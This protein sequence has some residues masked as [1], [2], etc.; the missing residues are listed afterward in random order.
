MASGGGPPNRG[1]GRTREL[2]A[3]AFARDTARAGVGSVL[4]VAGPAGSGKTWVCEAV[5]E[6]AAG[7]GFRVGWGT[8]WPGDG[9]PPLW[10]WQQALGPLVDRSTVTSLLGPSTPAPDDPAWFERCVAVVDRLRAL[11]AEQP[12]LLVLDDLHHAD[13]P[14]RSLARHVRGLALVL[15]VTHEAVTG[16]AVPGAGDDGDGGDD[17]LRALVREATALALHGLDRDDVAA[18]LALRGIEGLADTD[19]DFVTAAARGLPGTLHHLANTA[20]VDGLVAALVDLRVA[21]LPPDV[22]RAAAHAAVVA[23]DGTAPRLAEVAAVAPDVRLAPTAV[24]AE[25]ERRA[26]ARPDGADGFAF[27]HDQ[28]RAALIGTLDPAEVLD[29]HARIAGL[30]ATPPATLDRRRRRAEHALAA[31]PRSPADAGLAVQAVHD[32]AADL[33][34]AH[35]YERAADLLA[36]AEDA[37]RSVGAPPLP[38]ALLVTRGLALLRAGR[39]GAVREQFR[40]AATAADDE[41]DV[42]S[43]ARAALGQGGVW[44]LEE[45]SPLERE[46]FLDLQRRARAALP[47]DDAPGSEVTRLRLRLGIRLAA[48]EAYATGDLGPIEAQVEAARAAGDPALLAEALS[49]YHHTLLGPSHR[50]RRAEVCDEMVAVTGR[51][52]DDWWG[53]MALLWLT[54]DQFLAGNPRG[55]QTLRE[56]QERATALSGRHAAYIAQVMEAMLLQRAGRLAEAE[57]AAEAAFAVGTEVGDADAVGYYGGQLVTLR[58]I[59]GRAAEVLELA[60][61]TA[62][63]PTITPGNQAFTAT[64]ASL[65]AAAGDL[66]RARAALA[67][68]R[69]RLHEIPESSAWLV[70]LFSVVEAAHLLG[71]AGAAVEAAELM[72]PYA[73]LPVVGS[74]GVSCLGSVRR[75]LGLAAVTAGREGEG[76]RLLTEAIAHDERLGNRPLAALTSADLAAA[77]AG[78]GNVAVATSWYDRAIREGEAMGLTRRVDEWRAARAALVG[79]EA[80]GA[81]PA[82]PGT[83]VTL[84]V[85]ALPPTTSATTEPPGPTVP[86]GEPGPPGEPVPATVTAPDPASADGTIEHLGRTWR[87]CAAGREVVVPD[88]QGLHHLAELL[89]HPGVE[90]PAVDLAGGDPGEVA[91]PVLDDEA[92]AAYRARVTELEDELAEAEAHADPERAARARVEL[93]AVVEELTRSTGRFGRSRRF[94][95]SPERARTAVQKAVRRALDQIERADPTLGA[96]LRPAIHTGRTCSYTPT[97]HLPATWHRRGAGDAQP[98]P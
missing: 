78:L 83:A 90:I 24:A 18:L 6:A 35:D 93:D 40:R 71:D 74:L 73:D 11:A 22:R 72:A 42:E 38:A 59:Q 5:A 85:T 8:G 1:V 62:A 67:R 43:L 79:S 36:A 26:L 49:L 39:L 58:W 47:P 29:I 95:S 19:L 97:P 88:L 14:T 46:R 81:T 57:A 60:A 10:P 50:D 87:L 27:A 55:E 64:L 41:G 2:A 20:D 98:V 28:V 66:D 12:T 30:L 56:L 94:R 25:L 37:G 52:G 4:S 51:A 9:V 77:H 91:Q 54:A 45:R 96:A 3:A 44:L 53:L 82:T 15:V 7:E 21:E 65:A 80:T 86:P 84:A 61:E 68:L 75:S 17:D 32:V 31:A 63:S 69:G 34:A 33:L 16:P 76:V 89:T 48:E 70:T 23:T 13:A 92:L